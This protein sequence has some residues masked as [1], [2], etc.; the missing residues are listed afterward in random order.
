MS[1][2]LWEHS[3]GGATIN[4]HLGAE[5]EASPA[6]KPTALPTR[7]NSWPRMRGATAPMARTATTPKPTARATSLRRSIVKTTTA[8][9][10]ARKARAKEMRGGGREGSTATR[11][12]GCSVA[13]QPSS[14]SA[15][16]RSSS[17]NTTVRST[18]EVACS[19]SAASKSC[20]AGDSS[21][22]AAASA[23]ERA[24]GRLRGVER[25]GGVRGACWRC[26]GR[27]GGRWPRPGGRRMGLEASL[28][29]LALSTDT[30]YSIDRKRFLLEGQRRRTWPRPRQLSQISSTARVSSASTT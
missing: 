23:A 29:C 21:S 26:R 4:A 6:T 17:E 18:A 11:R 28:A 2:V 13:T 19:S 24:K 16:K 20:R 22:S 3:G 27:K 25:P 7:A 1:E 15:S 12:A 10:A 9:K 5:R 14:R 30:A 8:Q